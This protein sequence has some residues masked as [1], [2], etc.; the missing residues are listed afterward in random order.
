[1][2][3]IDAI[4]VGSGPNGLSAAIVLAQAG[5]KVV[6]FEAEK[7][8]G[9]GARSAEL[10][11]PGFVHDVCSAVHPFAVASPFWRTLPLGAYGLEWIEPSAMI[12]HP[13]DSGSA[14]L[15]ERSLDATAA[16][17]GQDRDGYMRTIGSVVED[18]ARLERAVLGP[19]TLP[20]HP[21]ALARF[22]LKA[23][24][25][26]ESL[27]ASA[28][29]S[30][31]TR[32]MF[33]GIAAHGML[34]L[35]RKLTAGIGL[36][37]GAMCHVPG[38]PIPR[39]GAQKITD[40]L[41]AHLQSLGGEVVAD[42]RVTNIDELPSAR[43]ILCD[44]SPKP[45]LRIAG[46]K[47]PRPYRHVLERYRYGMG[48]FKMDWALDAPIPWKADECRRAGTVHL[49]GTLQE[50]ADSEKAAWEGRISERPFVLLSQPTLFDPSRAPVAKQ[51]VWAYCHVP[52]GSTVNMLTTVEQQI[53]R[54]APGFRDRVLARSV[55][56]PGDIEAHNANLVGGD[57]ASGVTDL[58]QFFTR[59]GWRNYSTPV[60]G[61]Y[62]CSA[63]TP[64]GVGVHGMCGYFAAKLALREVF[65]SPDSGH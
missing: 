9:G 5:C 50:I 65:G 48:V 13:F 10:T 2:S 63:A 41:V 19:F 62:I 45:L 7:T 27:A 36:T 40:A 1:M 53:E 59:P 61:L 51:V 34:P 33:A 56:T 42:S 14:I 57:I 24:R 30:E 4:V 32:G 8:I 20:K 15:V 22:G 29:K 64:P 23:L 26:A 17:L 46:H 49:G 52:G 44:L 37:L 35:D 58:G 18:W 6:V 47:F 55:L 3:S 12:G 60:R 38:W 43:A 39:G 16:A 11:L 25:S 31:R 28:F 21:L 54:F